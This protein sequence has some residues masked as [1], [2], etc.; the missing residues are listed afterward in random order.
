MFK[1]FNL[2]IENAIA[3]FLGLGLIVFAFSIESENTVNIFEPTALLVVLGGSFCACFLHFSF[4]KV[5]SAI[6]SIKNL[7]VYKEETPIEDLELLSKISLFVR[8]NGV[9]SLKDIIPMV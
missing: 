6:K 7:F 9:L 8:K 4:V 2:N 3:M 1:K 5:F